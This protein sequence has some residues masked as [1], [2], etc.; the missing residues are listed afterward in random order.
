MKS[1]MPYVVSILLL[2]I[3]ALMA[4]YFMGP[5]LAPE[6]GA[7]IQAWWGFASSGELF[8]ELGYTLMRG[9]SGIILANI[10]GVA[11]G[12]AAGM[13]PGM[14]RLISPLVAALQACPA[15]VWITL[16]MV[17]AGTGSLV[18]VITVFAV[19]FPFVFSSTAQG[20]MGMD[21]RLFSMSRLYTVPKIR[22]FRSLILPGIWPYWLAAFSTVLAAG[23]KAAAVAEFLGSH[24]GI[25]ARIFWSYRRLNM[26]NLNAWALT[27]I[28]LGVL[29]E[30]AVILPL[31]RKAAR[32]EAKGRTEDAS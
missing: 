24:E 5:E 26:E 30:C 28:L 22:L 6:P 3:A 23:W 11:L 19:T 9:L 12:L 27:L 8:H 29:L 31:R 16:L 10:A 21:K 7:V 2:I 20:M 1:I 18:P 15:I 32:L 4:N 25:G 17:W 14:L 13:I